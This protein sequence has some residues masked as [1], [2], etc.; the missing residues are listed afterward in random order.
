MDA[1][2][3]KQQIEDLKRWFTA[4]CADP[5]RLR[6][7]ICL[8]LMAVGYLAVV[9]PLGERVVNA[10]DE[11]KK[12]K[13]ASR[14]ASAAA[15][16]VGERD[17]YEPR[18]T[19]RHDVVYWQAYVMRKLDAA[20]V[21]LNSLDP[22]EPISKFAFKIVRMQLSARATHYQDIVDFVDRI[23]HGEHVV[24]LEALTIDET[25]DSL[26]MSCS[27]LA[28][29]KPSL[30]LPSDSPPTA[31]VDAEQPP[32][33]EAEEPAGAEAP[34]DGDGTPAP[35]VSDGEAEGDGVPAEGEAPPAEGSDG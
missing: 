23:E 18:L 4:V 14:R 9:R 24:R 13:N 32:D 6:L 5:V 21:T 25:T 27:I 10:H 35:A 12:I 33:P 19:N 31:K 28:L 20:G 30:K 8:I 29:V 11:L 16:Y 7:Y 15:H 26:L 34:V 2:L 1:G 3:D 17:F 22:G